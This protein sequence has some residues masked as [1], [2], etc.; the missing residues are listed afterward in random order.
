MTR[1]FGIPF[2]L[3]AI[4]FLLPLARAAEWGGGLLLRR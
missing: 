1:S 3:A 2:A 4:A